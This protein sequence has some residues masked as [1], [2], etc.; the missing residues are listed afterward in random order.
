MREADGP[1]SC[2][3]AFAACV[4]VPWLPLSLPL[5]CLPPRAASPS[6]RG[7][8]PGLCPAGLGHDD[9]GADALRGARGEHGR[10]GPGVRPTQRE[11]VFG[12]LREEVAER[13]HG[14]LLEFVQ[15]IGTPRGPASILRCVTGSGSLPRRRVRAR[16][17]LWVRIGGLELRDEILGAVEGL[18]RGCGGARALGRGSL[19]RGRGSGVP[20]VRIFHRA[21]T[22]VARPPPAGRIPSARRSRQEVRRCLGMTSMT[23]PAGARQVRPQPQGGFDSPK[24]LG[25]GTL[26]TATFLN[27]PAA[28]GSGRPYPVAARVL[29]S[30]RL[31]WKRRKPPNLERYTSS[32]RVLLGARWCVKWATPLPRRQLLSAWLSQKLAHRDSA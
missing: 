4:V 22:F 15:A 23:I 13:V 32:V 17:G 26:Y 10:R 1:S 8:S 28:S 11:A 6:P 3:C 7:G 16:L 30:K 14:V 25:L 20:G 12:V 27:F 24:T 19:H 9:V 29:T 5:C 21:R 2:C 31:R 18:Y